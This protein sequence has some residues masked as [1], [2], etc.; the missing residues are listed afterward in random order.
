MLFIYHELEVRFCARAVRP[1]FQ[2]RWGLTVNWPWGRWVQSEK[3]PVWA[4]QDNFYRY[5]FIYGHFWDLKF[6]YWAERAW[7]LFMCS[8]ALFSQN[9]VLKSLLNRFKDVWG[10]WGHLPEVG[11]AAFPLVLVIDLNFNN[12]NRC[13]V[14]ILYIFVDKYGRIF[15]PDI[16]CVVAGELAKPSSRA[17]CIMCIRW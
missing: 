14:W 15:G 7:L 11:E 9:L 5:N 6:I 3:K 8:Q 10:R 12:T 16:L 1:F 4:Q 13:P 2:R 17:M